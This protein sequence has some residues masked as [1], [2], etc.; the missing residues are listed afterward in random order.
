MKSF[1]RATLGFIRSIDFATII[2]GALAGLG[3]WWGKI[4][5]FIARPVIKS[6]EDKIDEQIAQYE[7]EE[8]S[9]AEIDKKAEESVE[10]ISKAKTDEE[11]DEAFRDSLR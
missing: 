9:D 8:K 2:T 3:G 6:V 10:K 11:V 1:L 4:L 5:S 7:T